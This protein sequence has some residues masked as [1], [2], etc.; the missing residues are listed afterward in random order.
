MSKK[1]RGH[2]KGE[3]VGPEQGGHWVFSRGCGEPSGWP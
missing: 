3:F 2:A 1:H